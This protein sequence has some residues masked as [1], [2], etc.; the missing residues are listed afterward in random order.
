MADFT[1]NQ[2]HVKQIYLP[3]TYKIVMMTDQQNVKFKAYSNKISRIQQ[4]KCLTTLNL[5]D[6]IKFNITATL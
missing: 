4:K 3:D 5:Y 1:Y 6:L 2:I